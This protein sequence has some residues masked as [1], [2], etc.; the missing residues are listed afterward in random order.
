MTTSD[1]DVPIVLAREDLGSVDGDLGAVGAQRR[2]D[3]DL[4]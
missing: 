4:G 2:A 3:S 1:R